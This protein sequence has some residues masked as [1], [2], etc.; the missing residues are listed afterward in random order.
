MGSET[1]G[2]TTD[3]LTST[4]KRGARRDF[5]S[6]VMTVNTVAGAATMD[7]PARKSWNLSFVIRKPFHDLASPSSTPRR[8]RRY[9]SPEAAG[10]AAVG[11]MASPALHLPR[12]LLAVPTIPACSTSWAWVCGRIPG[13]GPTA[14]CAHGSV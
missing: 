2:A 13:Y 6:I 8:D 7:I 10:T 11:T 3:D 12:M 14:S 9:R 5:R 1:I 4:R